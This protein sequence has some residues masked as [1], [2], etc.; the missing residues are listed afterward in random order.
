VHDQCDQNSQ[1]ATKF[2]ANP[3]ATLISHGIEVIVRN[4]S[5]RFSPTSSHDHPSR[6]HRRG[7][8]IIAG[9]PLTVHGFRIA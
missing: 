3:T 8:R 2:P 4:A 5:N 7:H 1:I 6:H 9:V